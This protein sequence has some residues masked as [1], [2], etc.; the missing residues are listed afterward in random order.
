MKL[1]VYTTLTTFVQNK[2]QAADLFAERAR[3]G[4]Q[5]PRQGRVKRKKE[6]ISLFFFL[7]PASSFF[8]SS[9]LFMSID[10]GGQCAETSKFTLPLS[11]YLFISPSLLNGG[12]R[13][14]ERKGKG[15]IPGPSLGLR[16]GALLWNQSRLLVF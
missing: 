2:Q 12:K 8:F 5:G 9:F 4:K 3:F 6:K 10:H 16:R 11:I 15:R 1:Y 14:G 7:I 13:Q